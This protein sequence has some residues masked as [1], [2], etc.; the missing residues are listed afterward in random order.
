[1]STTHSPRY[2][3]QHGHWFHHLPPAAS[4]KN[5]SYPTLTQSSF[6]TLQFFPGRPVGLTSFCFKPSSCHLHETLQEQLSLATA[7]PDRETAPAILLCGPSARASLDSWLH[8]KTLTPPSNQDLCSQHS[9]ESSGICILNCTLPFFLVLWTL[10][11][12]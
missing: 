5:H 1:M 4:R 12:E 7:V 9:P 3:S 10:L 8:S 11:Y 2:S 6:D